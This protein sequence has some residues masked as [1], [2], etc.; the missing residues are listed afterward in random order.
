M[1]WGI[2]ENNPSAISASLGGDLFRDGQ[3]KWNLAVE[4]PHRDLNDGDI[5]IN[6]LESA[7]VG[8]PSAYHLV[9]EVDNDPS[10]VLHTFH[11]V[12]DGATAPGVGLIS[13][14]LPSFPQTRQHTF[15]IY[16]T[17]PE[18]ILCTGINCVLVKIGDKGS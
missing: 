14:P 7:T 6:V 15:Y 16:Q 3:L 8:Q 5:A 12:Q 18:T 11:Y 13:H 10:K 4:R 2:Y 1:N 9:F 17:D